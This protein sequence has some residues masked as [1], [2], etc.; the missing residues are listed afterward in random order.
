MKTDG[1][2]ADP[3][4]SDFNGGERRQQMHEDCPARLN[5]RSNQHIHAVTVAAR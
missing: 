4:I 2:A 5:R 1:M 3:Q